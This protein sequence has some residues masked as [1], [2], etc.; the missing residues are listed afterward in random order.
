MNWN[1]KTP[2]LAV[3]VLFLLSGSS[4]AQVPDNRSPKSILDYYF[5]LPHKYLSYLTA[6]SRSDREAAIQIKDLDGGFLPIETE[7]E[8]MKA[9][10]EIGNLPLT[11]ERK[12]SFTGSI[13][14]KDH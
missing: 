12:A 6:D 2:W 9:E 11:C 4:L 1:S 10:L 13:R 5:L 7:A 14:P 8:T 3:V